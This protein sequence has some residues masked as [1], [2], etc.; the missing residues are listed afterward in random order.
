RELEQL[1][2]CAVTTSTG[3]ALRLTPEVEARL[4]GAPDPPATTPE[5]LTREAIETALEA[6]GGNVTA[7]ARALGLSS[8]YVLY[9]RMKRLGVTSL[10]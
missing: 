2:W 9:R 8:R 3:R 6:A 4:D 1:L 7:A 5:S 10:P